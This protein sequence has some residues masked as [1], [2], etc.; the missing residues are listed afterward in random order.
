[1]K[2]TLLLIVLLLVMSE[3]LFSQTFNIAGSIKDSANKPVSMASVTIEKTKQGIAADESGHFYLSVSAGAKILVS[4]IGYKDTMLTIKNA[5]PLNIILRP[6]Y[7][8]LS[9]VMVKDNSAF[10]SQV[11]NQ[12]KN[13]IFQ[14]EAIHYKMENNLSSGISV[15]EGLD[16]SG[17]SYHVVTL[18]PGSNIY[19]GSSLPQFH[20][21]E[22]TRGSIYLFDVW[23]KGIVANINDS[24]IVDDPENLYNINKITGGINDDKRFS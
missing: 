11:S 6:S 12:I 21:K 10:M 14:A 1:M 9:D 16:A 5:E 18:R 7:N 19:Q 22:D 24:T 20:S 2:L 15:Y 23:M 4:A 13:E 17:N 8:K 3:C